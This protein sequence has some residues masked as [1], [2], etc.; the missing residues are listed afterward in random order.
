MSSSDEKEVTSSSNSS[1]GRILKR[2]MI[3]FVE[4]N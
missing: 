1:N 3:K 4:K 2:K